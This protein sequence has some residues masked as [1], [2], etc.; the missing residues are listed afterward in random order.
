MY[1]P[2]PPKTEARFVVTEQTT[3]T[4]RWE[5][6]PCSK[7]LGFIAFLKI[8]WEPEQTGIP[9]GRCCP[10]FIRHR[11]HDFHYDII[12]LGIQGKIIIG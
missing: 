4:I 8:Y 9:I 10:D 12:I 7:A 6:I 1:F 3:I 2:A 5:E 11:E